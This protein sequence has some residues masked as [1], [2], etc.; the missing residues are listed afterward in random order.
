MN[1][2]DFNITVKLGILLRYS[3]NQIKGNEKIIQLQHVSVNNSGNLTLALSVG[4]VLQEW[5]QDL[6]ASLY[7]YKIANI[8]ESPSLWNNVSIS[9]SSRKKYVAAVSCLKRAVYLNPFDWRFCYNLGLNL[10][11]LR[12]FASSFHFLRAATSLSNGDCNVM[13]LLASCLEQ[14]DDEVNTRSAHLKAAKK[15]MES[16][17]PIPILNCAIYLYNQDRKMYHHSITELL[18]QFESCC[19]EKKDLDQESEV[20]ITA[21]RLANAVNID[22]QL[23]TAAVNLDAGSE[24][25]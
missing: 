12:Q 4:A 3:G 24:S 19:S 13:T 22:S 17:S 7:R 11:V 14:L 10:Y 5:K 9:F 15:A 1:P 21:N 6:E 2:D 8:F 20:M 25:T 18:I 23:I 16:N